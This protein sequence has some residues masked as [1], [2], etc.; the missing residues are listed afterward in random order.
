MTYRANLP[1]SRRLPTLRNRRRFKPDPADKPV[2]GSRTGLLP[3]YFPNSPQ[4]DLDEGHQQV[5]HI[6]TYALPEIRGWAA[7][8]AG[9]ALLD[10][11]ITLEQRI[12]DSDPGDRGFRLDVGDPR[13]RIVY[14]SY[15]CR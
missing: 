4:H 12:T 14:F 7:H 9:Y 3:Q 15:S 2:L 11:L 1:G 8:I 6:G 5:A 10:V 13:Q